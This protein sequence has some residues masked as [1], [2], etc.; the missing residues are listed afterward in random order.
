MKSFR[1][2]NKLKKIILDCK[3][4][5][6]AFSGGADSTFLLYVTSKVLPKD[7][8]VAVTANSATYP[9]QELALAKNIAKVLK[10]KHKII[11]T[12]ELSDKK[13]VT[14]S[15]NR[16]YFCKKELF[17]RLKHIAKRNGLKNVLDASNISDRKD[18][19]PGTK[20]RT[21]LGVR[22]PLQEAGI[23]KEEI[24][25]IS[26]ALKLDTWDKPSLACLASR[27]PY[28]TPISKKTLIRIEQGEEL[29]QA[30]GFGQVRL[31]DYSG[32]CRIEVLK[33]DIPHLVAK[34]KYVIDS[35]KKLGYNYVTM[36]LEGFRSGS[37]NEVIKR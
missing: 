17:T 36:D 10:V 12:R 7:K 16:C 33:K 13:F 31:R 22:S 5:V 1:K 25:N 20:A 37:M 30:M 6:I 18:F 24:R 8:V 15:V 11:N 26:R 29:L 9:K 2:L 14:N 32:L 28:G 27:V 34:G 23:N 3:S 4:V 21:E 19:R 35:L